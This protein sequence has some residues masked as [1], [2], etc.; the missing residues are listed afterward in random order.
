MSVDLLQELKLII[1]IVVLGNKTDLRLQNHEHSCK[2]SVEKYF[3]TGHNIHYTKL[4]F[5][6][7]VHSTYQIHQ[8]KHHI[9]ENR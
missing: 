4:Q 1:K 6:M 9:I 5:I 7:F 8:R 3:E 2:N